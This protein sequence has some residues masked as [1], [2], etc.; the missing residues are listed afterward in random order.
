MVL[1]IGIC[2]IHLWENIAGYSNFGSYTGDGT[3]GQAITTGFRPTW[4]L[5]KSTVGNDNW[6]VYDSTRGFTAGG[7]LQPDNTSA[8]DTFQAPQI[9]VSDTGFSITSGGVAQ[10]LNANGNLITYWAFK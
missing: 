9:A 6:R 3:T 4:V 10:G 5:I 2:I 1:K 7:F 8:E